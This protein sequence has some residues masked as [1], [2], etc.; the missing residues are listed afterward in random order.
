MTYMYTYTYTYTYIHTFVYIYTYSINIYT[1][2]SVCCF[3]L[4]TRYWGIVT[5]PVSFLK[6]GDLG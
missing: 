5:V 4:L 1:Y 6:S 3:V 2:I